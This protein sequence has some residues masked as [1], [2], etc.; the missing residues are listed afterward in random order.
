MF[1]AFLAH[2]QEILYC[3]VSSYGKQ[4]N[5][6]Q[7]RTKDLTIPQYEQLKSGYFRVL[8]IMHIEVLSSSSVVTSTS[9][10]GVIAYL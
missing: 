9:R 7:K 10:E 8:C 1:R 6:E 4:D 2:N 3:L 5:I